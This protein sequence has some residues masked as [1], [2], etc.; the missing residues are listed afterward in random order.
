MSQTIEVI[1]S[2]QGATTIQTKGFAGA[3]CR[4]ASRDLELAL[5]HRTVEQ[6]TSEFHDVQDLTRA[7]TSQG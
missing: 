4:E 5:G 2:P 1:V 7:T 6:L 3:S